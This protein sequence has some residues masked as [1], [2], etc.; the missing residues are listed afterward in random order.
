MNSEAIYNIS[1][2]YCHTCIRDVEPCYFLSIHY[3]DICMC[4][5]PKRISAPGDILIN[6][7][8]LNYKSYFITITNS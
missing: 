7:M 8:T 6:I 1:A 5:I 4:G 2:L 3:N